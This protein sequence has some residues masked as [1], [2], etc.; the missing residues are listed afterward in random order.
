MKFYASLT[1]IPSRL[2]HIG[3]CIKYILRDKGFEQV[4]LNVPEKTLS[5]K[6]YPEE[7]LTK[8]QNTFGERLHINRIP[9]DFGPI[10]KLVGCLDL[11]TD[12]E[13]VVVVFDDDRQLMKSITGLIGDRISGEINSVYSL[14][15]WCFGTGYRIRVDNLV[16]EEVDSLMGTTCIA[17]QRKLIDKDD[18]L[19][20]KSTD[21]RLIKLDDLRISGYLSSRGIRRVS[22]GVNAKIYLRDI[23]YPGTE[24]LSNNARFWM[25]NK[26][27]IDEFVRE[28]IFNKSS[29]SIGSSMEFFVFSLL[30]SVILLIVA[31]YLFYRGSLYYSLFVILSIFLAIVSYISLQ[32]FIM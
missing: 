12:P 9:K 23:E 6:T 27:V 19:N 3:L 7:E 2:P 28:G 21:Q 8:L 22:M 18:L 32:N 13:D 31:G 20:Y 24:K 14:G 17:F 16:D 5:G 1:T 30:T 15:G 25:D 11:V 10:T 26:A 4:I 29:S